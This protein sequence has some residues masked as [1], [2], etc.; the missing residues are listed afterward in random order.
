[1][2]AQLR[3]VRHRRLADVGRGD[4]NVVRDLGLRHQLLVVQPQ[5]LDVVRLRDVQVG[6]VEAGD[7][8][9]VVQER[10]AVLA[11][12]LEG[13]AVDQLTLCVTVVVDVEVVLGVVGERVEVRT[14]RGLLEGNPVRHDRRRVRL[15][16][17]D[18]RVHVRVVVLGSARDQRGLPV[19]GGG[20]R[21]RRQR[22]RTGGREPPAASAPHTRVARVLR[23]APL[24]EIGVMPSVLC[25][26]CLTHAIRSGRPG[27]LVESQTSLRRLSQLVSSTG[28]LLSRRPPEPVGAGRATVPVADRGT[29]TGGQGTNRPRRQELISGG[30]AFSAR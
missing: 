13:V 8:T 24:L 12:R 26:T 11:V 4:R 16:R 1:M 9:R 28:R 20:G 5:Q 15:V 3:V 14:A 7:R 25:P 27:G 22:R 21:P 2:V 18:E 19:A 10:V 6:V 23:P 17:A 29:V 30:R